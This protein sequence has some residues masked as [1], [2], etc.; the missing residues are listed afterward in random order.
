[1]AH[2]PVLLV[3]GQRDSGVV[4]FVHHTPLVNAFQAAGATRLTEVWL[5][6]DHAFSDKRIALAQTLLDWLA[7]LS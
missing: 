1:L 2:L 5:D 3:A 6:S 4:P 7:T